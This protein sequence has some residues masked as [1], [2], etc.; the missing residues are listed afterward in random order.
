MN[1]TSSLNI[2]N[3]AISSL[4]GFFESVLPILIPVIIAVMVLFAGIGWLKRLWH[5]RV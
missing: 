2:V 4:T 1:P 5:R 3:G